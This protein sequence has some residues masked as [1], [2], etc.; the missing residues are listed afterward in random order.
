LFEFLHHKDSC[1]RCDNG[2]M[3][4]KLQILVRHD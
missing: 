2:F 4:T 3:V 1:F